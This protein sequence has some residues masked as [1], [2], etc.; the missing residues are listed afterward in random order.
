[1][2]SYDSP[3]L[4][5]MWNDAT[6]RVVSGDS[7]TDSQKY[8]RLAKAQNAVVEDIAS[9]HPRCLYPTGAIPTLATADQSVFTFGT[10]ITPMGKTGIFP[11]LSAIPSNPWQP[12]VDYLD[13][14][15]QI[16]IPD[17]GTYAG[18]LYWYGITMPADISASQAPGLFPISSRKLIVYRAVADFAAEAGRNMELANTYEAKYADQFARSMLVWRTAFRGGGALAP[19]GDHGVGSMNGGSAWWSA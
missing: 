6:G 9:R 18:T 3:D 4:L 19:L 11:S 12:G 8:A 2:S 5:A 13:E 15:T 1:M 14:G 10:G 16:R 17:N 7:I